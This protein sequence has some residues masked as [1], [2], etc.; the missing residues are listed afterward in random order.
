[1]L[2]IHS[3]FPRQ[4]RRNHHADDNDDDVNVER[5][6]FDNRRWRRVNIDADR[7]RSGAGPSPEERLVGR[8]HNDHR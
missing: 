1:M 4:Q 2:I 7:V 6:E 3:K 5:H 8:E